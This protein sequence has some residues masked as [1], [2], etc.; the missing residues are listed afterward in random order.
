MEY[1]DGI[2]WLRVMLKLDLNDWLLIGCVLSA[3]TA[4][5]LAMRLVPPNPLYGFRTR[6]T[7]SDPAVWYAANA[8]AGR[9]MFVASL[10]S[11]AIVLYSP[12]RTAGGWTA[13]AIVMVPIALATL[14]GF[15]CLRHLRE[16]AQ[17][18]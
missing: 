5:P 7:R 6:F 2:E 17:R 13:I 18:R 15:V 4:L 16:T 9:A 8:F 3:L 14:A 11:A 10:V 1:I 12:V